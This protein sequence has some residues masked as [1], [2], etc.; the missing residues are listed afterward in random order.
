MEERIELAEARVTAERI[1]AKKEVDRTTFFVNSQ[2]IKASV[3]T[4]D[5][6]QFIPGIHVDLFRN[7]S[8][9]G[10]RNVLILVNGMERS[11]EFL[12]QLDPQRIDKVEIHMHPGAEF[13]TD[14]SGVINVILKE[15]D[16][17]GFSGHMYSEIPVKLNEV[18]AFPAVNL[19]LSLKK[20]NLFASYDGE[21][22]YFD[23]SGINKLSITAS[24]QETRISK[25]GSKH[26]EYWSH[27]L[28]YG[29]DYSLNQKNQLSLY[30]Y[31]NP[32]SQEFD[33]VIELEES[34]GDSILN[35]REGK[36]DDKAGI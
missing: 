12:S 15:G 35:S 9:E 23:I 22:S 7:I 28:H 30:G 26:Q 4:M 19:D 1:K 16:N 21:L 5:L 27:K 8:L 6:I 24:G 31:V 3:T 25:T 17:R 36:Q 29:I 2:M 10:K 14:A 13:R 11:A 34:K 33:G 20:I 18:Y 32:W